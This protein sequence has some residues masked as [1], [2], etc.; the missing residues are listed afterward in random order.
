MITQ[1]YSARFVQPFAQLL[2]GYERYPSKSLE[3]LNAIDGDSRISMQA[4]HLLAAEQ[5]QQTG[6]PDIGLKAARIMP[7]GRVGALTYAAHSAATLREAI[8]VTAR[9]A[10]LFCDGAIV[11]LQVQG[12][13]A[14]LRLG[15]TVAPPRA[16][17]DFSISTWYLN[18]GYP[19]AGREI[20]YECWFSYR[21]PQYTTEYDRTFTQ[22]GLRFGA[23]FDGFVFSREVLDVALPSAD[24]TVHL[25]L[26]QHL[27]L[28]MAE[29]SQRRTFAGVVRQIISRELVH[30][31]PTAATVAGQLRMSAR[32]LNR[33]L[34]CE[35]TT[36]GTVL[37]QLR[38]ELALR[39]V[40]TRDV[41]LSEASSRL[42]FSH[43]E[44]FHRA[45]KR[46][47]GQTPFA[48]KRER[49]L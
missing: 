2:A 9:Y 33:R 25:L 46:W 38:H 17:T 14:I 48:Y 16:I 12:K 6:D 30:T 20:G 18:R 4:A 39:Y 37:D 15:S 49:R 28:S 45:F 27:D 34:G 21:K 13:Q 47:T 32:T 31:K 41:S 36:F 23:P 10:P 3:T 42:R 19:E 24:S 11:D 43:P 22:A 8:E 26:R 7:F 5:V 44:S 35:G 40:G 29:L 1:C